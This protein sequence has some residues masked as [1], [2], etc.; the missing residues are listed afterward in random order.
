MALLPR[1][2]RI[3]EGPDVEGTLDFSYSNEALMTAS[4][5]GQPLGDLRWFEEEMLPT[6]DDF[7]SMTGVKDLDLNTPDNYTLSQNYPNP[8]NPNTTISY[9]LGKAAQVDL[10]VYNSLGQ[11]VKTLV[12]GVKKTAGNHSVKWNG[13][14]ESG[15]AMPTGVYFYRLEADNHTQ[16]KKMILMR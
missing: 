1:D 14:G 3:M 16:M 7:S 5:Q 4:T 11:R 9:Q 13:L 10:A 6:N 2:S 15:Q 8:F 12:N